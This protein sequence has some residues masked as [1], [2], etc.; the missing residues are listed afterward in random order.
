MERDDFMESSTK[1]TASISALSRLALTRRQMLL[2][3]VIEL[4]E[5]PDV[6]R[7]GTDNAVRPLIC[8]K[9]TAAFRRRQIRLVVRPGCIPKQQKL[10]HF[11]PDRA[12]VHA[13]WVAVRTY[14]YVPPRAPEPMNRRR[15]LRHNAIEAWETMRKTG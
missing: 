1:R 11:K 8:Q 13:Q 4:A 9:R 15:L 7:V 14:S 5:D 10:C 6:C 3:N 12:T 2:R